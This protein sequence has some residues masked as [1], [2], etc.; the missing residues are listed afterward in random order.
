MK[1]TLYSN[2]L[3]HLQTP[4]C[5]EMYKYLGNDFAFISTEKT[6]LERLESG[7]K[8]CSHYPYNINSYENSAN[9]NKAIQ[10]GIDSDIVIFGAAPEIFIKER[11]RLNKHTF[12][13]NERF[14]KKGMWQILDPRN[15]IYMLLYHTKYRRKN[16]YMLCASAY[17]ANDLELF[18]A[19]P[20]KKYKWGYFTEVKGLDIDYIIS[21]KPKERIEILWVARFLDWKHPE[22]AVNL[23]FQLKSKGYNF[24]LN[25]AGLG[26]MADKIQRL[27]IKLNLSE[28]VTLL[29]GIPNEDVRNYMLSANI[30]IFTSDRGE[31]WGVVLNEAM[32][33]GCAIVASD[34]IGAVPYLINKTNGLCFKSKNLAS[35]LKQTEILINNKA[36]RNNLSRNA[37]STIS[38]IWTPQQAASNFLQLSNGILTGQD[39]IFKE[40]PCSKANSI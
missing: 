4:F 17:T 27:I 22:L 29:G 9:F 33:C 25:M 38:G 5:D 40:G 15:F 37:Y 6:P 21:Q 1:I 14:F 24:H 23:A 34:A 10:L 18:F 30:F 12:R 11:L 39:V 13:Y 26:P 20:E 16:L 32:N 19:Y 7:Y 28:F 35:L 2:Y 36:L 8:D 31:G 3:N